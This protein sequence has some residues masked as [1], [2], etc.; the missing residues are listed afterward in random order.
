MNYLF[1]TLEQSGKTIQFIPDVLYEVEGDWVLILRG[2]DQMLNQMAE[3]VYLDVVGQNIRIKP[4]STQIR[5]HPG[6]PPD[7]GFVVFA[8]PPE[9]SGKVMSGFPLFQHA[10]GVADVRNEE[11]ARQQDKVLRDIADVIIEIQETQQASG[12]LPTDEPVSVATIGDELAISN[13]TPETIY[14]VVF[15]QEILPLIEWAPCQHPDNCP[16]DRI[17]AGQRVHLPLKT[18]A[19][20]DTN[21]VVIF[22]WHLVKN[23]EGDSYHD[24]GIFEIDVKIR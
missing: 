5:K 24:D 14:Y 9:P 8:N 20:A 10:G 17:E 15:P 4:D 2:D 22:W 7:I 13:N 6:C 19:N 23:P 3:E 1:T 18:V 12:R 11:E 21:T 16:Q